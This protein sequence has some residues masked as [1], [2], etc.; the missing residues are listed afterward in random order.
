M[1]TSKIFDTLPAEE[2]KY[3][4]THN[5]EVKSGM[6]VMPQ[7][8][9][10]PAPSIA[11][12][13]VED[14]QM[15][16]LTNFYGKTYHLWQVDR[17]DPIPLGEPNLMGSFTKEEQLPVELKEELRKRDKELGVDT[18][19]KK[20]RREYIVE[21]NLSE[22]EFELKYLVAFSSPRRMMVARSLHNQKE[23][24]FAPLIIA[25]KA[26]SFDIFLRGRYCMEVKL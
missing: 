25:F 14:A 10:S 9:T 22:G 18:E 15:Q 26:D 7:P 21:A 6:L 13:K 23:K 16:N 19:L 1:I 2:K 17:G 24:P 5:F 4:H 20:S 11:W 8:K 3:W 12:E